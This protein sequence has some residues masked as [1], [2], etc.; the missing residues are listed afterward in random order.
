M[1]DSSKNSQRELQCLKQQ[2]DD[3]T[4]Q[5]EE[6]GI[7]P[8]GSRS[9]KSRVVHSSKVEYEAPYEW[10]KR[11]SKKNGN[12]VQ[13]EFLPYKYKGDNFNKLEIMKQGSKDVI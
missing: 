10:S 3:L 7:L 6:L 12:K 9:T 4:K 11:S 1:D 8:K 2:L 5:M 13:E